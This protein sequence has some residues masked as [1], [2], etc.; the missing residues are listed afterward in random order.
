MLTRV[1]S[2]ILAVCRKLGRIVPKQADI[3]S[4]MGW[5]MLFVKYLN[6]Q[7]RHAV[8]EDKRQ[9]ISDAL[10]GVHEHFEDH[11]LRRAC[12]QIKRL[13]KKPIQPFIMPHDEQGHPAKDY[14][15]TRSIVVRHWTRI[16]DGQL[17]SFVERLQDQRRCF[18]A[19]PREPVRCQLDNV[20]SVHSLASLFAKAPRFKASGEDCIGG[21]V[22]AA[23]PFD[24][25]RVF[26]R[27]NVKSRS[28]AWSRYNGLVA[29]FM[30]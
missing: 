21:A 13:S 17:N 30:N 8:R 25:A 3:S 14:A 12:M 23:C 18:S 9:W 11:S 29:L 5:C 6:K 20:P 27:W 24:L 2:V 15:A 19:H 26:T 4:L 28:R 1:K 7:T 10:Q 22:L 16:I